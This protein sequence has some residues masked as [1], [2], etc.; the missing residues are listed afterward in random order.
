VRKLVF[1]P[2][3]EKRLEEIVWWTLDTFGPSQAEKY[4][5]ELL[6]RCMGILD[7]ST[8]TQNCSVIMQPGQTTPLHFARSGK[9][10]IICLMQDERCVIVGLLHSSSDLASQLE[11]LSKSFDNLG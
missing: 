9:H 8:L 4:E 2:F 11:K 6:Q 1:T 5:K 7:G 3:A 10:L